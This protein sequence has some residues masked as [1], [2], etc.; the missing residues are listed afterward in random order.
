MSDWDIT[1]DYVDKRDKHLKKKKWA[2]NCE[3]LQQEHPEW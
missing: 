3:K 1:M 2:L